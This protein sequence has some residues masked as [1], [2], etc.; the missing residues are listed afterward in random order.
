M[1]LVT[2]EQ[3]YSFKNLRVQM[4]EVIILLSEG[5][6]GSSVSVTTLSNFSELFPD[7]INVPI[8]RGSKTQERYFTFEGFFSLSLSTERHGSI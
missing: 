8:I 2:E 5:G 3:L 6:V 1:V 7:R 4:V